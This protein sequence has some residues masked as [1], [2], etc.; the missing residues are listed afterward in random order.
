MKKARLVLLVA[1]LCLPKLAGAQ[2]GLYS[3]VLRNAGFEEGASEAS[4][5]DWTRFGN[6]YRYDYPQAHE[7]S[8]AVLAYGNW[9]PTNPPDWNGSGVYQDHPAREGEIWEASIWARVDNVITGRF[10]G[11]VQFSFLNANSQS[12]YE[13]RS[14]RQLLAGMPAGSW[15]QLAARAKATRNT[16]Y[17]RMRPIIVQSPDFEGCAVWFDDAALR[18]VPASTFHFAGREWMQVDGYYTPGPNFYSTNSAVV[19]ERGRLHLKLQ[20]LDGKWH[21]A[22]VETLA[23]LGFGEY[24][25]HL[26]NRVDRLDSNLVL[27]LF[28]Y[29][30]EP[31]YGT[32]EN[33]VDIEISHAFPGMQTNMLLYTIQPYTIGGNSTPFRL[34]LTN[35]LSTH[36]FIWRPDQVYFESFHG[37]AP[38]SPDSNSLIAT[39]TFL[40]RGIPIE[41]NE[42]AYM[43]L[44]LF[45][46]NAPANTQEVEVIISDFIF[47]PFNGFILLDEFEAA[48]RSNAWTV[49]GDVAA[50]RQTN[51]C[52]VIHPPADAASAGYVTSGFIRRNERGTRYVFSATLTSVAVTRARSGDDV[53]AVMALSENDPSAWAASSAAWLE[54][55][56]DAD[57]DTLAIVW[58]AK[59]NEPHAGGHVR[60]E[61]VVTSAAARVHAPGGI[62]LC[63]ALD[64][65]QYEVSLRDAS[66]TGI[67]LQTN[68]GASSGLH[69]LSE[70]LNRPYWFVGARNSALDSEGI[71]AWSRA[72][73]GVLDQGQAMDLELAGF[74][75]GQLRVQFPG[76]F[77]AP[78]ALYAST[79]TP[80]RG[81]VCIQSNRISASPMERVTLDPVNGSAVFYRILSPP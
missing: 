1:F 51:G 42:K 64:P 43:N 22:F 24:R 6:A 35:D 59:T 46:T 76:A 23:P 52:L 2:E 29:A 73:A 48:Q 5:T 54:A 36:R 53:C 27:G 17:I 78:Y 81:Y 77:Q 79:N 11:E 3:N 33:E 28:T 32:N 67:A 4:I 9:W 60:F 13:V 61:G 62:E 10:F 66:G 30:Q 50:V 14:A 63:L 15:T 47:I 12:I 34:P 21:C 19:D 55:R 45:F 8:R 26:D 25:W 38:A 7:G 72:S 31:V 71:V 58:L 16:A 74:A 56:Y 75:D 65:G 18:R 40:G 49:A 70:Q 37:H 68:Q 39:H 69:Q 57:N 44:W 41:T 20:W 80:D